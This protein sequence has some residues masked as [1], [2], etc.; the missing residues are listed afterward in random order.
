M[1]KKILFT[2]CLTEYCQHIFKVALDLAIE[3]KA[4][5]WIYHGLETTAESQTP[6]EEEIKATEERLKETCVQAMKN[7][8]F[9]DYM[10]NVSAGKPSREITSL[11]RNAG[12][13]V[14]VMGTST[15]TPLS[16]AESAQSLHLGPVVSEVLLSAPCPVLVVPPQLVPGLARG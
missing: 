15:R 4:K 14:I 11:A 8:G 13:D 3:N 7:R 1:Y 10:I 9:S 5:L 12:I 16:A 2:S 6:S